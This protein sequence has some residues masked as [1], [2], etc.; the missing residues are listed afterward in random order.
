[1]AR[2]YGG[3][4]CDHREVIGRAVRFARASS[5]TASVALLVAVNLLPLLGVLLAPAAFK[6]PTIL[7]LYWVE[8]GI[9]GLLNVPKI[10]LASGPLEPATRTVDVRSVAPD[11]GRRSGPTEKAILVP[12]FL[13]HYG[14]FWLVHGVFVFALPAIAGV[15]GFT[16][17]RTLEDGS[18][19]FF[20]PTLAEPNW[21]AV[22]FGSIAF[23]VSRIASFFWNYV[24]RREYLRVTPMQEMFAP[25]GRVVVLHLTILLGAFVTLSIGSPV[26]AIVVLVLLKTGLDLWLHLREHGRVQLGAATG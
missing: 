14:T 24:G 9:V 18:I 8:N 20:N 25:Y 1:M 6:V 16:D 13:V 4:P 26:G 11:I 22:A 19:Q 5:S 21:G 15:G 2:L 12:F 23:A 7:V 17:F 10:L 3:R